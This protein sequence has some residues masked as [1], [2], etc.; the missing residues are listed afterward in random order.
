MIN[1]T[2][3]QPAPECLAIEKAKKS[4]ENYG[5]GDVI[6]RIKDDFHNKCYLCEEKYI[7]AINVEHFL[8]HRGT[9]RDLM[10]DWNNLF[11]ACVH[12]NST[13][14]VLEN[15]LDCTK[16]NPVIC[17]VLKFEINPIFPKEHVI[18]TALNNESVTLETAKLLNL[19]YNGTQT[20]RKISEAENIRHKVCVVLNNFLELLN[21]Y[22]DDNRLN[23]NFKVIF[24]RKIIKEL[25][26]DSSFT[27]F[28]IWVVKS[29][30]TFMV[31]FGE[32]LP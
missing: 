2:K 3:S 30:P 14:S 24:K 20:S 12:C 28:K 17:D 22:F 32:H 8:P 15:I 7:S 27:A 11:F 29:N 9:D 4:S 13:K 10:F 25:K 1:V 6:N 16:S 26:S 5:C 18:V 19:I 23:E 31:E 21:D